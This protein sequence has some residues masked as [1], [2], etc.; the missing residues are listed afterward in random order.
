M[1][2]F[3]CLVFISRKVLNDCVNKACVT[4]LKAQ[5]M[6]RQGDV[7]PVGMKYVNNLFCVPWPYH[8]K[9]SFFLFYTRELFL[10]FGAFF[11]KHISMGRVVE[12]VIS[13]CV[14]GL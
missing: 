4:Y 7:S 8:V 10:I 5:V 12:P 13:D 3:D 14:P 2:I 1:F 6:S 11:L 9:Y